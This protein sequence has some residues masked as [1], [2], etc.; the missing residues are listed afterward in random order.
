MCEQR[1]FVQ[2]VYQRG[3]DKTKLDSYS[4]TKERWYQDEQGRSHVE[5]IKHR[6]I[7]FVNGQ[8]VI[9]RVDDKGRLIEYMPD[10]P[11][12]MGKV[13]KFIRE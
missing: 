2:I 4:K 5:D 10:V 12:S 8:K 6:R 11:V 9:E 3:V 7:N 13:P 1:G